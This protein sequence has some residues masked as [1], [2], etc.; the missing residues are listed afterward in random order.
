MARR[1]G[2]PRRDP[3][4]PRLTPQVTLRGR[5]AWA[6]ER[7]AAFGMGA[8]RS[9][10]WIVQQWLNGEGKRELA[11]SYGIDIREYAPP[12][13]VVA[14]ESVRSRRERTS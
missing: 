8:A 6:V 7:L 12:N 9:V 3:D 5:E 11:E 14:I 10:A 1:P 2:R 4:E 13:K